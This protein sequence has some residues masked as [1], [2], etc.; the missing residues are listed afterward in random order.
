MS[1][2]RRMLMVANEKTLPIIDGHEYVDLGLPSGTLWATMNVG[3]S[4]IFDIGLYFQWGKIIGYTTGASSPAYDNNKYKNASDPD[5]L[6]IED[7]GVFSYW[8]GGWRIPSKEQLEELK[9]YTIETS[10]SNYKNSGISG[11]LY[12]STINNKFLFF[13]NTGIYAP[14][15]NKKMQDSHVCFQ[16]RTR[17]LLTINRG[18]EKC[19]EF[20][21]Y[22]ANIIT[23]EFRSYLTPLRGVH[24]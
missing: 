9:Q 12:T 2:I 19:V 5:E 10:I 17:S 8:G 23:D 16:S 14:R 11:R 20:L 3:A 21:T 22:K 6:N 13:P 24:L 7:D 4:T 1:A 15:N 18:N